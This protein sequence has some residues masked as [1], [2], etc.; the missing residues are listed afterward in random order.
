MPKSSPGDFLTAIASSRLNY[1]NYPNNTNSINNK[2]MGLLDSIKQTA[3]VASQKVSDGT[4]K[5]KTSISEVKLEDITANLNIYEK[6]FSE[7]ELL[8]KIGKFGKS[9]GAT[10][11]YPVF[12]LFNLLK[13][14]D[15][16]MKEKA[17]IIGTLGYFILPLD[18]LPD[19]LVGVGYA[20]DVAALTAAVTALASCITEDI[21]NE[22][23]SQLRKVFGNFDEKALDSITNIIKGANNFIN[24]RQ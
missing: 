10:V 8:Q 16:N 9:I 11:L 22:S 4:N 24:K 2:F 7:S 13:S 20:D 15:I 1:P 19:A 6:Y 21:Q 18:L 14:G 5:I 3:S 17:M 12:L 23:K